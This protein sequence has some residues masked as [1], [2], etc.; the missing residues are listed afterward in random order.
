MLKA[1]FIFQAECN[2]VFSLGGL[3]QKRDVYFTTMARMNVG[4]PVYSLT[5]MNQELLGDTED[6]E[7]LKR[8]CFVNKGHFHYSLVCVS[9]LSF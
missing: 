2:S 1:Q 5:M 3:E 4:R 9:V 8:D 6:R 7:K